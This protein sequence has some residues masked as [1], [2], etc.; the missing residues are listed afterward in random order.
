MGHDTLKE[1]H[2]QPTGEP[3]I[4]LAILAVHDRPAHQ[5]E[6]EEQRPATPVSTQEDAPIDTIALVCLAVQHASS[7]W[8][9]RAAEFAFPLYLIDIFPNSLV[10]ASVY[11]I[12]LLLFSLFCSPLLGT[13]IDATRRRRLQ[14]VRIF[15]ASQKASVA[16]SYAAFALL[17]YF[18]ASQLQPS[19]RWAAFVGLSLVGTIVVLSNTGIAV[20]VE[21]DWV[22]QIARGEERRLLRLNTILRR[23][24]LLSKLLAPLFVSLL[25]STL[26]NR[27]SSVVLVSVNCLSL[28]FEWVWINVVYSR[29]TE[30][31]PTAEAVS[32][33]PQARF[34]DDF[35]RATYSGRSFPSSRL[36]TMRAL[37]AKVLASIA[38][39]RRRLDD[40]MR[41]PTLPTSVALALLY[42]SVLSFDSTFLTYLKQSH[43]SALPSG[44]ASNGIV[45]VH[46]PHGTHSPTIS[47]RDAFISGM[48]A[49]CVLAGLAGTYLMPWM[50]RRIGLVRTGSWCLAQQ[51]VSLVP[52]VLCLWHG[53]GLQWNTALL[54]TGLAA[55]RVGLWG[56][57]LTQLSLL[58]QQLY[59]HPNASFHF[60]TQQS[61]L[62]VFDVS[63]FVLT[64]LWRKPAQFSRPATVS[65]ATIALA[66][67]IYVV[68]FARRQRG[69]LFH[70]PSGWVRLGSGGNSKKTGDADRRIADSTC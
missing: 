20:A 61:L 57:D 51:T 41:L 35:V 68:L 15:I 38:V 6:D 56:Y 25:T 65:L 53:V 27:L 32:T 14:T 62:S 8:G 44:Y 21:R 11:G 3:P 50:T 67:G 7:S 17:L 52:S 47:Y 1:R 60:A 69:H 24:D 30:L 66:W 10:P 63:H 28:V 64:L 48:R 19:V 9:Y 18:G 23:I 55:S 59:G 26:G 54:F 2:G 45:T 33:R 40:F 29:F 5:D 42:T 46:P 34:R 49:V 39:A 31:H 36:L 13:Y 37:L 70:L 43:P 12:V 16:V 22:T 58:Q 4:P